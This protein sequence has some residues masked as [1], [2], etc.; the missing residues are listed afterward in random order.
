M[1]KALLAVL[2]SAML[3]LFAASF[4]AGADSTYNGQIMDSACALMGSHDGMASGHGVKAAKECT[5]SCVKAGA[6]F[7]LYDAASKKVYKLDDQQKPVPFAGEKVKVT[8]TLDKAT[9]TIHVTDIKA[10][11]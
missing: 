3:V 7:V 11:S 6:K 10:G 8:G 5:L 4:S 9:N 1:K 2:G